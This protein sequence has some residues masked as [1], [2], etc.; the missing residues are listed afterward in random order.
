MPLPL[1]SATLLRRVLL[2]D[3]IASAATAALVIAGA[4][5]LREPLGLPVPL[6]RGA[7]LVLVP[8]VAFVV[9]AAVREAIPVGAVRAVIVC[10]ALWALASLAVL[11]LGLV[12]PTK[13]G[14]A[15]IVGQALAVAVLGGLQHVA[16]GR[17]RTASA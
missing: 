13:L 2:L 4:D 1:P 9:L 3:A 16:L 7:G 15:F 8:F 10:N 12:M 14:A 5:L 6:L 11:G 17:L